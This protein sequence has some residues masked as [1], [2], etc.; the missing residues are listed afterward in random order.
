MKA[1]I[2]T[3]EGMLALD[4]ILDCSKSP[5]IVIS[6]LS[7]DDYLSEARKLRQLD[8]VFGRCGQGR[9]KTAEGF[10]QFEQGNPP[11]SG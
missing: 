5:Q 3:S 9:G 10:F 6:P 8:Q 11:D 2:S 7:F 1:G 4:K